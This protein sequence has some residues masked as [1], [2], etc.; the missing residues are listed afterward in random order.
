MIKKASILLIFWILAFQVKGQMGNV[1]HWET[2][3]FD[4]DLWHYHIGVTPP[5]AGWNQPGFNTVSWPKAPGP[6][7]LGDTG[8][9]TQTGM[10]PSL[11]LRMEFFLFD[12]SNID[13]IIISADYDDAYVAYLN[14]YEVGRENIG[15][16]W[17]EPQYT[18]TA[19][20]PYESRKA[21]G[22]NPFRVYVPRVQLRYALKN[23]L[24]VFA[25]QVHNLEA[26]DP[27]IFARFYLHAGI[28]DSS[29]TYNK[30][31]SW[32]IEPPIFQSW[33]NLP[34]F[35]ITTGDSLRDA[36]TRIPG[37]LEIVYDSTKTNHGFYEKANYLNSHISI[38]PRGN[39]TR[40]FPKKSYRVEIEDGS[41]N[42]KETA[43]LGLPVENDYILHGEYT[44]K[45]LL[46]NYLTYTLS[47]Q[48]GHW[49]SRFTP[50][51]LILNDYYTGLYFLGENVKR[52]KNRVNIDKL[53]AWDTTG[54][55]ITGGYLL[56]VDWDN[57]VGVNAFK[58]DVDTSFP[59]FGNFTF[60]HADPELPI[61][62]PK[63]LAYIKNY[64]S[65]FYRLLLSE[66]FNHPIYGYHQYID[67]KS[68]A[69]YF[70]LNELTKNVDA[71]RYSLYLHKHHV[72]NGGKLHMGPVWDFNLGYGNVDFG[73]IQPQFHFGWIY[74]TGRQRLFWYARLMEDETFANYLNC[75]WFYLR[76]NILSEDHIYQIL[77]NTV[78]QMGEGLN[79]NNFLWDPFGRYIW[80]NYVIKNSYQEELQYLKDWI[81]LRLNWMDIHLP[82][83]CNE[84]F[85]NAEPAFSTKNDL[86]IFPNPASNFLEIA[87]TNN[88]KV[89]SVEIFNSIGSKVYYCQNNCNNLQIS[90]LKNGMYLL[91]IKNQTD[92]IFY[93][94]FTKTIF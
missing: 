32:W 52:D 36:F 78:A 16:P 46:R 90:Q 89:V 88:D 86:K 17:V 59:G 57:Q 35:R 5:A 70:I 91:K 68:F 21:Q 4:N 10:T 13:A 84:T 64:I 83:N 43:L 66:D 75:R 73:V 49:A 80:P 7:G 77:D 19:Y 24:N 33:S 81:S 38:R 53:Q 56:K 55:D 67:F 31:P 76:S 1:N 60:Q 74:D 48:M 23:G 62:H 12:T 65:D 44:D 25:V 82:G 39:S 27:D 58:P 6:F 50:V 61:M 42:P 9:V 22:L 51:E 2:L 37:K 94:K 15:T 8:V 79:R 69:D 18:D 20:E 87:F 41:G 47:R 40:E 63:Q 92:E 72:H 30:P 45:T 71:Y 54:F 28:K 11:Y 3:I 29:F 14:G 34:V 26:D 85:T 93:Q